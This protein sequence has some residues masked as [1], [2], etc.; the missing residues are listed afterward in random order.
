MITDNLIKEAS[1]ETASVMVR[2]SGE[3]KIKHYKPIK[4]GGI[5]GKRAGVRGTDFI[6]FKDVRTFDYGSFQQII[7]TV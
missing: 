3:H 7:F 5:W 1:E 4:R 2:E 6:P